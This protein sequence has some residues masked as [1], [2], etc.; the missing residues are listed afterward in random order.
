MEKGPQNSNNGNNII[1]VS[2]IG[3]DAVVVI[4]GN[5]VAQ[6]TVRPTQSDIGRNKVG[7]PKVKCT[8]EQKYCFI[9]YSHASNIIFDKATFAAKCIDTTKI[10]NE[11]K[12][13]IHKISDDNPGMKQ[14]VRQFED[15]VRLVL[16]TYSYMRIYI[17]THTQTHTHT[18]T[19]IH[20]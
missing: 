16:Y 5:T 4:T 6:P 18:H 7:T 10:Q 20:I 3:T 13:G 8:N 17:Y 15:I 12:K 11:C 9:K 19:Y 14:I 2:N 1:T